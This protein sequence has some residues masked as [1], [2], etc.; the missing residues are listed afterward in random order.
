MYIQ[1]YI[2]VYMYTY[3]QLYM[4][5]CIYTYIYNLGI[6]VLFNYTCSFPLD[7]TFLYSPFPE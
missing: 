3:I 2:Y 4:H 6:K 7:C 1:L 5:I